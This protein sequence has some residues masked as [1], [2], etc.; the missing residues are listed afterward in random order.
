MNN[1]LI[2]SSVKNFV[3]LD[4]NDFIL[5]LDSNVISIYISHKK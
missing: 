1:N 2:T 4:L 5:E 3:G